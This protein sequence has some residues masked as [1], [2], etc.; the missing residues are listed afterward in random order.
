MVHKTSV[1]RGSLIYRNVNRVLD[2]FMY[3]M[4]AKL[5]EYRSKGFDK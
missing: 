5:I 2:P 1:C 3:I 4:L